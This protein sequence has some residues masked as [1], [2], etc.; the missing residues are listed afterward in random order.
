[1]IMYKDYTYKYIHWEDDEV[2]KWRIRNDT[3]WVKHPKEKWT[4]CIT[5]SDAEYGIFHRK[6]IE[7]VELALSIDSMLR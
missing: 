2:S 6:I 5:D 3:L 4:K 7:E 1:M